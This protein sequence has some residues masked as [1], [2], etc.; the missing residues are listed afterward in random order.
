ML[1]KIAMSVLDS[2]VNVETEIFLVRFFISSLIT[3]CRSF[4]TSLLCAIFIYLC[5]ILRKWWRMLCLN[6]P[7]PNYIHWA[8]RTTI[9]LLTSCEIPF[10]KCLHALFTAE[11]GQKLLAHLVN[12]SSLISQHCILLSVCVLMFIL[13]CGHSPSVVSSTSERLGKYL[14][15]NEDVGRWHLWQ[16]PY[17]YFFLI[18]S[19]THICQS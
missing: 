5:A 15:K 11:W 13:I 7:F 8:T 6:S 19:N 14:V 4:T 17:Y 10:E 3:V 18:S 1:S 12:V 16:Q 2:W 9:F